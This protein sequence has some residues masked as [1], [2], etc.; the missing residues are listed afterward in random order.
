LSQCDTGLSICLAKQAELSESDR[1]DSEQRE[2]IIRT[3][4]DLWRVE[5]DMDDDEYG[6]YVP[7]VVRYGPDAIARFA[8][9][10]EKVNVDLW[11]HSEVISS[12]G[13]AADVADFEASLF[14]GENQASEE[15]LAAYVEIELWDRVALTQLKLGRI[16]EGVATAKRHLRAVDELA[17]FAAEL[18]RVDGPAH[19]PRAISLIEDH[20]WEIE[21]RNPEDDA[22]IEAWLAYHYTMD[23]RA[24]E[25]L[26][27]ADK[28]FSRDPTLEAWQTVRLAAALP[29]Q[30]D[31]AWSS[32]QGT[33]ESQ[34]KAKELWYELVLVYADAGRIDDAVQAMGKV[35]QQSANDPFMFTESELMALR[36]TVA[37]AQ[38]RIDP[39]GTIRIYRE[40][41]DSAIAGRTREMYQQAMPS[42]ARIKFVLEREG[43]EEEWKEMVRGIRE[44]HRNLRAFIE[45]LNAADL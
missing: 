38:E 29:G 17:L 28:W 36:I 40:T 15:L 43:R 45:E 30:P 5:G 23:G 24:A 25:G 8:T 39:D 42:L 12:P 14:G 10:A 41:V 33:M 22:Q 11:L 26:R 4:Y 44:K 21:G 9:T 20:A 31:D 16:D 2:R 34:L 6:D 13:K 35:Y 27:L 3:I 1:L 18:A 7:E 19:L 32:R 37:E